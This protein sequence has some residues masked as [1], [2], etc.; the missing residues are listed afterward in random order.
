MLVQTLLDFDAW[1][2]HKTEDG[3]IYSYN[4]LYGY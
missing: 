4:S 1:T 2:A 3:A